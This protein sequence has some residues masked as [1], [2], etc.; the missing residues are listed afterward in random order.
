MR[1]DE[2]KYIDAALDITEKFCSGC[3]KFRA[4]KDGKWKKA[5]LGKAKRWICIN[6]YNK[7]TRR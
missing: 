4:T 1:R 6:C 3:N 2:S 5:A 7:I